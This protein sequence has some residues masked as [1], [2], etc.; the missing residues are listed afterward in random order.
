MTIRSS[1][2]LGLVCMAS[3][4]IAGAVPIAATH[5][6]TALN[7][8]WLTVLEPGKHDV[9][10]LFATAP[11]ARSPLAM[12]VFEAGAPQTAEFAIAERTVID[13]W[14]LDRARDG[15]VHHG[16]NDGHGATSPPLALASAPTASVSVPEPGTIGLMGLGLLLLAGLTRRL[17]GGAPL[18]ARYDRA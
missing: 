14:N 12:T 18:P 11:T 9:T 3:P 1:I 8:R 10:E 4:A 5:L 7:G 6:P 17:H 15:F 16:S 13:R 2:L